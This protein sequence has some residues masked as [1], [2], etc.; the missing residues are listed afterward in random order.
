MWL[1]DLLPQ[2]MPNVR[3]MTYGYN[4]SFRNFTVEQDIRSISAKLLSELMDLRSDGVV[5]GFQLKGGN[6]CVPLQGAS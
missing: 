1:Q 5:S 6:F 3:I 4:A 2:A